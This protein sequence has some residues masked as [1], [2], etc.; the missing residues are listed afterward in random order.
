[1]LTTVHMRRRHASL[2]L[3]AAL[4]CEATPVPFDE[5][6]WEMDPDAGPIPYG[7]W[8]LNGYV[9]EPGLVEVGERFGLVVFSTATR[10]PGYGVGDLLPLVENLGLRVNLRLVGDHA[11]YTDGDGNFDLDMWKAMLDPWRDSGAEP[12]I[13]NGTF[14]YHMM[15]DDIGEFPGHSPGAPELEAMAR[16][17]EEVLPGLATLVRANAAEMPVPEGGRYAHV[18]ASVNQYHAINGDVRDYTE[19]QVAAAEDLGLDLVMG[20]N[21]ADGGDGRSGQPGWGEG[22]WAM[23]ADEIRDY[24]TVLSAAPGCVMFLNWEYDGEEPWSD[25]TIGSHYFNQPDLAEA[26]ADLGER[27]AGD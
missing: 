21:I 17:S 20:M 5:Q 12:Y 4:G 18:D 19:L 27:L 7:F 6:G 16:Y 24:G 26:L 25:G 8:G 9:D 22:K 23:S 10:H 3:L 2:L 1:M 13:E 14:A 15:L 11:Y